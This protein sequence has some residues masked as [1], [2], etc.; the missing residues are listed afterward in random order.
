M[1][2]S[3]F[4]SK[5]LSGRN[6]MTRKSFVGKRDS[7]ASPR[8]ICEELNAG[9]STVFVGRLSTLHAS[10]TSPFRRPRGPPISHRKL[11]LHASNFRLARC[12]AER[13]QLL[14]WTTDSSRW[15]LNELA[16][17]RGDRLSATRSCP[18]LRYTVA[19]KVALLVSHLLFPDASASIPTIVPPKKGM[20]GP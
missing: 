14:V 2:C 20:A 11:P 8:R 9:A 13:K 10:G 6:A 18:A 17:S 4:Y 1:S 16:P 3:E 5:A 12:E 19:L 15:P 7:R